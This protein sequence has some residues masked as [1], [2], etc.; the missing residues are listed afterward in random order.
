MIKLAVPQNV[1]S[2][3]LRLYYAGSIIA[4]DKNGGDAVYWVTLAG[5]IGCFLFSLVVVRRLYQCKQAGGWK[6]LCT[7]SLALTLI[8]RRSCWYYSGWNIMRAFVIIS[9]A[10][11]P[12]KKP[13]ET[14]TYL[15]VTVGIVLS[16]HWKH[17]YYFV[18]FVFQC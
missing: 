14:F 8:Y 1:G 6:K 10:S 9:V 16:I 5:F 12:S 13:D 11:M 4:G 3:G 15:A 2:Y 7:D 18:V 17:L